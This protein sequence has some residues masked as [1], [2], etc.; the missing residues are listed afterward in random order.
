[1]RPA[2]SYRVSNCAKLRPRAPAQGWPALG[3]ASLA[4][5]LGCAPLVSSEAAPFRLAMLQQRS[6]RIRK[7]STHDKII[8]DPE[9]PGARP[10]S[11]SS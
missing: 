6:S 9:Q 4:Y 5:R 7:D 1:M 3:T 8:R 2:A 11:P 10:A